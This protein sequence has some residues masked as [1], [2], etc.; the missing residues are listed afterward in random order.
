MSDEHVV[1]AVQPSTIEPETEEQR[2]AREASFKLWREGVREGRRSVNVSTA[3]SRLRGKQGEANSR[4]L[5]YNANRPGGR[6]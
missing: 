4:W 3:A 6:L 1:H 5:S 2:L